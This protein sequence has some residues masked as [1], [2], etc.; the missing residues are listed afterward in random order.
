MSLPGESDAKILKPS[1]EQ[2]L[3]GP[4]ANLKLALPFLVI[5][6]A[7]LYC[8]HGSVLLEVGK[9]K[10]EGTWRKEKEDVV[11]GV[12]QR[13]RLRQESVCSDFEGSVCSQE[14]GGE[15]NPSGEEK[16]LIRE[17]VPLQSSS[18]VIPQ[19]AP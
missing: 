7:T 6:R 3:M 18:S 19:G 13:L 12:P 9:T 11:C 16:E 10:K 2:V 14:K 15:G 17:G 5:D 1:Q 4:S 8:H